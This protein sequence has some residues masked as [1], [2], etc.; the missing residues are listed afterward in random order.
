MIYKRFSFPAAVI[1]FGFL[2]LVV[3]HALA[4]GGQNDT[5][6]VL[7]LPDL[8]WALE[9][10]EPGFTIKEKKIND[11]GD[12]IMLLAENVSKRVILSAFLEKAAGTGDARACRDHYWKL[13][14]KSPLK[15][16]DIRMYESGPMAIVEYFVPEVSAVKVEQKNINAY[17][18]MGDYWI[19]VHLSQI[20][21]KAG[22]EDPL[23]AILN[24]IRINEAYVPTIREQFAYA[25]YYY[26]KKDYP[27]AAMHYERILNRSN[28]GTTLNRNSWRVAVDQLGM[29]YGLSGEPAK[30]KDV[31]EWAIG[32]D[33][34]YPMFYYNLACAFAEM[35]NPGEALRN[36]RLAYQ[37]RHNMLSKESFPDPIKDPSFKKFLKDKQFRAELDK[38]K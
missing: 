6:L 5:R 35:D 21:Y 13:A 8:S 23:P 20:S 4:E 12:G 22:P 28:P 10:A 37:Y 16:T 34:E 3:S 29:S 7:T 36:L 31:L 32:I 19:D 9:I 1:V 14:S 11:R 25:S 27:K 17:L 2:S 30:A 24:S 38:M 18:A 33:A 26:L 15:K